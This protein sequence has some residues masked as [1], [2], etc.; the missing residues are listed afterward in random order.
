M[1]IKFVKNSLSADIKL[2]GL[3]YQE[4]MINFLLN[5]F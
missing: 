4:I 1:V 2:E 3:E 5:N